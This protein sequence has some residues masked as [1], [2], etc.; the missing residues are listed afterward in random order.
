MQGSDGRLD[1]T[2]SWGR[3]LHTGECPWRAMGELARGQAVS[4]VWVC[5]VVCRTNGHAVEVVETGGMPSLH[6]SLHG[7]HSRGPFAKGK[8]NL[9]LGQRIGAACWGRLH[10]EKPDVA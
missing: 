1:V 4:V 5:C 3:A 10:R 6:A 7:V 9:C 2:S 8:R